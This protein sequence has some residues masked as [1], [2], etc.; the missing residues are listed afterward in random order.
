M[1][2][3]D[4]ASNK[5]DANHKLLSLKTGSIEPHPTNKGKIVMTTLEIN[6]MGGMPS[7][8]LSWMM[9]MVAPSMMKGLEQRYIANIRNKGETISCR[10]R[11]D[12]GEEKSSR[13]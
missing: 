6:T 13:K 9:G 11:E 7:W 4:V 10:R 12:P 8:A 1:F 5:L 2:P 3:W